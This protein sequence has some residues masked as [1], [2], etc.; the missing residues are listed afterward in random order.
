MWTLTHPQ[1]SYNYV[2]QRSLIT[3]F[4]LA[5]DKPN[6][7][8]KNGKT[9]IRSVQCAQFSVNPI[10]WLR[11]ALENGEKGCYLSTYRTESYGWGGTQLSLMIEGC[12]T[13]WVLGSTFLSLKWHIQ[14][15]CHVPQTTTDKMLSP[16]WIQANQQNKLHFRKHHE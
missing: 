12:S 11:Q 9:T 1:S 14:T 6:H 2:F 15:Y 10:N 4:N 13:K 8:N 16:H 5:S 7:W 3:H